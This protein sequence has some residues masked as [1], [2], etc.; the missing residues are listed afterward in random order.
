[1]RFGAGKYTY[2]VVENWAKLPDGWRFGWIPAVAVD[3]QDRVFVYSRSEHPLVIFDREGNFL[4]EWGA[5][6]LQDAHGIQSLQLQLHE[7]KPTIL[8]CWLVWIP[9]RTYSSSC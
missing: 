2:E 5:G 4:E 3:S 6:V 7:M 8:M 9:K 1:M